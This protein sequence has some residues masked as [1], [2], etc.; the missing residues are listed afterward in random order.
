[1]A[2]YKCSFHLD[3]SFNT[4]NLR[5]PKSKAPLNS[6]NNFISIGEDEKYFHLKAKGIP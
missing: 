5:S 3:I 6:K 1:M 4:A 2:F